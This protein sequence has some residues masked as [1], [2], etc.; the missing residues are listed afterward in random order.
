MAKSP[1]MG[2]LS[3]AT[4]WRCV[5]LDEGHLIKNE[6]SEISRAVRRMHCATALL[7]TGTPLQV[8]GAAA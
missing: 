3:G 1:G 7:L 2:C 4:W 6:A 8:V 5:V